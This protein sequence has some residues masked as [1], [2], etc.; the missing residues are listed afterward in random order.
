MVSRAKD[1][2]CDR[3]SQGFGYKWHQKNLQWIVMLADAKSRFVFYAY[4]SLD[5]WDRWS[6]PMCIAYLQDRCSWPQDRTTDRPDKDAVETRSGPE[7]GFGRHSFL[8]S[9]RQDGWARSLNIRDV[10]SWG[11]RTYRVSCDRRWRSAS[12]SAR[13][14]DTTRWSTPWCST[15]AVFLRRQQPQLLTCPEISQLLSRRQTLISLLRESRDRV[16]DEPSFTCAT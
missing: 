8:N 3:R 5:S 15:P 16:V 12:Q 9:V 4:H 2:W 14:G 7:V 13:Q 10:R 11:E 1:G 6:H